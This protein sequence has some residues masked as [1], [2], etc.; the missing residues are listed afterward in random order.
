MNAEKAWRKGDAP[1]VVVINH[2]C[3]RRELGAHG[4]L[5]GRIA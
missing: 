5:F 1:Y 4:T 2:G 3:R